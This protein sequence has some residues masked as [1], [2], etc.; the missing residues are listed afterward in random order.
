M[1]PRGCKGKAL[2]TAGKSKYQKVKEVIRQE[3]SMF[4]YSDATSYE[5]MTYFAK[6]A[7][8]LIQGS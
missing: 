2:A 3:R 8:R 6:K 5:E 7:A 1:K 4:N